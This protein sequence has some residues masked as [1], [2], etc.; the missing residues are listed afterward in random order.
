MKTITYIQMLALIY[1]HQ[2]MMN[3][4]YIRLWVLLDSLVE[5]TESVGDNAHLPVIGDM[6]N[7]IM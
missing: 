6:H 3:R 1:P 4:I 7:D 2:N 5:R